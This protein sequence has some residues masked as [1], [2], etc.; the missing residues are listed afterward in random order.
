MS[1][2]LPR[3]LSHAYFLFSRS[4]SILLQQSYVSPNTAE[5]LLKNYSVSV[6]RE[7]M[8]DL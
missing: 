8:S 2:G 4:K 5:M 1:A 7:S 3:S 6:L